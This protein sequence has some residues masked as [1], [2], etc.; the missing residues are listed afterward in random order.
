MK[1]GYFLS[2][3]L[4]AGFDNSVRILAR[5]LISDRTA[6]QN[7]TPTKEAGVSLSK[8]TGAN[9]SRGNGDGPHTKRHEDGGDDAR[10]N[11]PRHHSS[12]GDEV[13]YRR[14]PVQPLR[15]RGTQQMRAAALSCLK[16]LQPRPREIPMFLPC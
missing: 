12:D 3:G 9:P 14:R 16:Q 15:R 13:R 11:R 2:L 6:S 1:V 5:V 4:T 8:L 10:T 7:E